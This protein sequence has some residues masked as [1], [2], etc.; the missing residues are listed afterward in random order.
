MTLKKAEN[1]LVDRGFHKSKGEWKN[2]LTGE[3]AFIYYL[4]NNKYKPEIE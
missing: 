2:P 1:F 3:V 4:G